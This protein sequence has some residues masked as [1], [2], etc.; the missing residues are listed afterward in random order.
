MPRAIGIVILTIAAFFVV[1]LLS[2]RLT[3]MKMF[4]F[5]FGGIVLAIGISFVIA[6]AGGDMR[7][8]RRMWMVYDRAMPPDQGY[9]WLCCSFLTWLYY[10]FTGLKKVRAD[11]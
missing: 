7:R 5:V 1:Y 10:K 11:W 3:D 4:L 9:S 2:D 6:L 8:M